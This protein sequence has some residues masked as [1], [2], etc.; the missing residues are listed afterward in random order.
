[1]RIFAWRARHAVPLQ[2]WRTAATAFI[3]LAAV[4]FTVRA[5]QKPLPAEATSDPILRALRTVLARSKSQLKMDNVA[6]PFYIEYR[7]FDVEQFD[8]SAAFGALRD[9]NRTKIRLLRAVVR[10]GD[11]KLDSFF[12]AGQGVSDIL[13][14]D[15]DEL[16]IRHQVWLATDQAYKRASEA[17]SNKKAMLKQLN[18][19][20]PVDD[21]AKAEPV[22][23]I[24]PL[25][26]LDADPAKWTKMLES[27][28]SVYKNDP[29]IQ[30][31]NANMNFTALSEYFVNTEGTI[32][33]HGS[34]HY[35]IVMSASEQ[36]P[37][38]MRLERSPQY[39]A[40]HIEE[41]P[42]PDQFQNDALKL[43]QNMK[44]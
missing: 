9:Q 31:F 35:Q 4:P 16:A 39:T 40:N 7:V 26:K 17:F 6:S 36:A 32:T 37:D 44:T 11:Y 21:F 28:T 3:L 2:N 42:T 34:A 33:R 38:G 18:I 14:L 25:A 43:V 27:A 23:S 15:N 8:A 29:Q 13:P 24:G 5:Q 10:L 19:D 20:Q 12:N 22:V 41:L 30:A 1:M